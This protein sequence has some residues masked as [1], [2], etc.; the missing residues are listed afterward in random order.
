MYLTQ[1]CKECHKTNEKI[2]L[3]KKVYSTSTEANHEENREKSKQAEILERR[4]TK[5]KETIEDLI[6]ENKQYSKRVKFLIEENTKLHYNANK[7]AEAIDDTI[8]QNTVLLEEIK[9]LRETQKADEILNTQETKCTQC[10]WKSKTPTQLQGHLLKHGKQYICPKCSSGFTTKDMFE[11]HDK[12]MH[13]QKTIPE[14][15]CVPCDKT[16]ITSVALKQHNLSKHKD[17]QNLPVGHPNYNSKTIVCGNCGECFKDNKDMTNHIVTCHV[18]QDSFQTVCKHYRNGMCRNPNQCKWSPIIEMEH[19]GEAFN[20]VECE[21]EFA[22]KSEY[23]IHCRNHKGDLNCMKCDTMFE[24]RK[25]INHHVK[26][27][28]SKNMNIEMPVCS[29]FLQGRCTRPMCNYRHPEQEKSKPQG[30]QTK[31]LLCKRGPACWYKANNDCHYQHPEDEDNKPPHP[32]HKTKPCRFGDECWN[33]S[34]CAFFHKSDRSDFQINQRKKVQPKQRVSN[35][36]Q[37]Y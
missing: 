37:N 12:E 21:E 2:N 8:S 27:M 3:L 17:V 29:F 23:N 28:H 16:F 18:N 20:C 7:D 36:W 35:V 25:G 1:E 26:Q 11:A 10:E 19:K 30:R 4:N 32:N 24:T 34:Q 9:V 33:L 31:V 15:S 13:K 14:I 22:T 5:L 6:T